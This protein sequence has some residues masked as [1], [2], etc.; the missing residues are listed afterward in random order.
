LTKHKKI[1]R[2][3]EHRDTRKSKASDH[4]DFEGSQESRA[5]KR[6]AVVKIPTRKAKGD[7]RKEAG[8]R[9]GQERAERELESIVT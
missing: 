4:L 2:N 8:T 1:A 3:T 9:T 6:V 7:R 5:M